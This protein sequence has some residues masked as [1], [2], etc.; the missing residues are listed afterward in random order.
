MMANEILIFTCAGD[1]AMEVSTFDRDGC[2]NMAED[3][4]YVASSQR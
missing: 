4:E 2:E 3:I 1:S